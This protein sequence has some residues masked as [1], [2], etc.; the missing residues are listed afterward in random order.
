MI[1]KFIKKLPGKKIYSTCGYEILERRYLINW[2]YLGIYIHNIIT[3]DRDP[4][5][6]HDHPWSWSFSIILKGYYSEEKLIGKQ[7]IKKDFNR[8]QINVLKRTTFHR[9]ASISPFGVWSI[10]FRGR[11]TQNDGFLVEKKPGHYQYLSYEE[12]AFEYTRPIK[13]NNEVI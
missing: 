3:E 9:I 5:V 6:F 7:K 10:Y 4:K 1:R 12:A 11:K 8:G 13:S 2:T